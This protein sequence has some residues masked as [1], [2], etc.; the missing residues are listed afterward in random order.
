MKKWVKN[1][2]AIIF[3][4]LI[5]L[6]PIGNYSVKASTLAEQIAELEEKI[7]Q[8]KKNSSDYSDLVALYQKET[9][10]LDQQ[11]AQTQ[12]KID[13]LNIEIANIQIKLEAAGKDLQEATSNR[14]LYQQQLDERLKIVYMKGNL[15]YLDILFVAESFS[16]CRPPTRLWAA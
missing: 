1:T 7:E 15:N 4:I 9:E 11:I 10:L 8:A 16:M 13:Q 2:I 3:A 12:A 14:E 5:I 6:S